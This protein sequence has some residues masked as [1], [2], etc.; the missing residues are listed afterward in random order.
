MARIKPP[1]DAA[2]GAHLLRKFLDDHELS[3]PTFAEQ[4]GLHRLV[5]QKL[6]KG[7]TK[8]VFVDLAYAIQEA[9]DGAVPWVSWLRN[10]PAKA[11]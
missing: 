9:T 11:A 10:E 3:I 2:E 8:R 4:H 6:M 5:L 1:Q 7:A